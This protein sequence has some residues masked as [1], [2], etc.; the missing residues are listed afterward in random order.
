VSADISCSILPPLAENKYYE[1]SL[2]PATGG[3]IGEKIKRLKGVL[4]HIGLNVGLAC[5]KAIGAKVFQE[6]EDPHEVDTPETYQALLISKE[7]V[8]LRSA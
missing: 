5:Y 7:E 6:L 3:K 2:F 8:F 4:E 1:M